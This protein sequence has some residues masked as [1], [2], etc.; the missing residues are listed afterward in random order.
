M[1]L[2]RKL[3]EKFLLKTSAPFVPLSDGSALPNCHQISPIEPISYEKL[4]FGI[5]QGL[6]QLI[7]ARYGSLGYCESSGIPTWYL[8]TSLANDTTTGM[9]DDVDDQETVPQFA[10][11]RVHQMIE[12]FF[13]HNPLSVIVSKTLLLHEYRNGTHDEALLATILADASQRV[14]AAVKD[15]D[16]SPCS[17][18]LQWA[19]KCLRNRS[20][21][22]VSLSTVQTLIIIGW[23]MICNSEAR[24]GY[25]YVEL[26]RV[27][28]YRFQVRRTA[29]LDTGTYRVNGIDVSE[30]EFELVQRMYWL[31]FAL[32]LWAALQMNLPL[33]EEMPLHAPMGFPPISPDVSAVMKLDRES[34]NVA[35]LRIQK[36][37]VWQLW[38][39]SH[40]ASTIAPIHEICIRASS[41]AVSNTGDGWESHLLTKLQHLLKGSGSFSHM[42][43]EVRLVLSDGLSK[44]QEEMY[45][46]PSQIF[47]FTAYSIMVI[48]LLFPR[49]DIVGIETDISRST[50][51]DV[52]HFMTLFKSA[53][54]ATELAFAVEPQIMDV[55]EPH[56]V[57]LL[58]LGIDACSRVLERL[59]NKGITGSPEERELV[60]NHSSALTEL[61]QAFYGICKDYRLR[62][63]VSVRVV[64]KRLKA[65]HTGM[66]PPN[67]APLHSS[68]QLPMAAEMPLSVLDWASDTLLTDDGVRCNDFMTD[69]N[70][71]LQ[72]AD[73][74]LGN[75]NHE[76]QPPMSFS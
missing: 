73:A 43:S 12:V 22:Q 6:V 60:K 14:D 15:E 72:W 18:L 36:S 11:H 75:L 45:N 59:S 28:T 20:L 34:G 49:F 24:K 76:M 27:L 70:L 3:E 66:Q 61:S 30:V 41:I 65:F 64:K 35:T 7:L 68:S 26:A 52:F 67:W 47:A 69:D 5:T 54:C 19:I 46:H 40:I 13:I 53:T 1:E 39:L 62:K 29:S 33:C 23:H 58:I 48:H 25:C 4:F 9:F 63:V 16:P 50:L 21:E 2:Q 37:I 55:V 17:R 74:N 31:T 57:E 44:L 10:E 56:L 71:D 38:P 32:E 8:V 42:C 51:N